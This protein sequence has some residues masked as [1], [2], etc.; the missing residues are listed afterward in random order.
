MNDIHAGE[1]AECGHDF[2]VIM[3]ETPRHPSIGR[4]GFYHLDQACALLE[5]VQQEP[6]YREAPANEAGNLMHVAW[7]CGQAVTPRR[8]RDTLRVFVDR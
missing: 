5:A 1:C 2:Y 4:L 8:A 3:Q 7:F 6:S